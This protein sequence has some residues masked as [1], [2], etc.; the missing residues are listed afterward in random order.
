MIFWKRSPSFPRWPLTRYSDLE[1][2]GFYNW[3]I[4]RSFC[5]TLC[6]NSEPLLRHRQ[7]VHNLHIFW[8]QES[9]R[10]F[11]DFKIIKKFYFM[12]LSSS[13]IHLIYDRY[14]SIDLHYCFPPWYI[15]LKRLRVSWTGV[16]SVHSLVGP[17]VHLYRDYSK[18]WICSRM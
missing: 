11:I 4:S 10:M 16:E 12:Y 9:L 2:T 14:Q 18:I 6:S 7:A 8:S 17:K 5:A 15:I 13:R 1:I 3:N